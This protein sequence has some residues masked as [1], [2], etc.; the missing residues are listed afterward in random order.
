[1]RVTTD[2]SATPCVTNA[3]LFQNP[4]I[5]DSA[6]GT[7]TVRD[8][9]EAARLESQA[10]ALCGACP[11]R[12][13]C[14]YDSVVKHDVAGYVAG[15]TERER[16]LMRTTLGV[17]VQPEDLDTLAGVTG[18]HRQVNHEEVLRLRR[19][20]PHESLETIAQRLGCS[21][22]TVKR[23]L[24]KARSGESPTL[25]VVLPTRSEV[26]KAYARVVAPSRTARRVA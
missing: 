21:L 6:R 13:Q 8:R 12:E 18:P 5:E 7:T 11:L 14:L 15:T 2:V 16:H 25:R 23:H 20:N 4:L 19:A 22:S 10:R 1:M 9:T 17:R 24:R 26:L 3:A